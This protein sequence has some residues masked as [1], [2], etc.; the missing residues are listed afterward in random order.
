MTTRSN[1]PTFALAIVV[2][3]ASVC[4]AGAGCGGDKKPAAKPPRLVRVETVRASGAAQRHSF[5][6]VAKAGVAAALSFKVAGSVARVAVKV[7]ARVMRGQLIAA[8]DPSDYR[9]KVREAQAGAQQARAQLRKARADYTRARKLYANRSIA[10]KD[11]D[12]ARMAADSAR[13][14]VQVASQRAALASKQLSYCTL[15]APRDGAVAEVPVKVN[16]NVRAGQAVVT[17][18]SGG[19]AEVTFNV[20][21][22]LVGTFARGDT[23]SAR[24]S[25]LGNKRFSATITEIAPATVKKSTA[26]PVTAK[27]AAT[28][29]V[30]AVRAGMSA[31]IEVGAGKRAAASAPTAR[32]IVPAHTVL[33]D[34]KGRYCFVVRSGKDK[35]TV[36]IE[37]RAVKTGAL[38]RGGIVV[39]DGLRAGDKLVNAGLRFVRHGQVVRL[40]VGGAR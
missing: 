39:T 16:E 9:L 8:L 37:R 5:S 21:A 29:G 26:Y 27:L 22:A 36:T 1:S 4:I 20:P 35:R 40:Q 32:V 2:A 33:E 31:E 12:A 38:A 3:S 30:E 10:L 23:I 6:G 19:T 7:G 11:L 24:F 14:S 15:R 18:N 25:A 13:A 34:G 28:P 17:L